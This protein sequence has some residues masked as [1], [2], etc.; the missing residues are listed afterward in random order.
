MDDKQS[1]DHD[2]TMSA[3]K[4][5]LDLGSVENNNIQSTHDK[6]F[7]KRLLRKIDWRLLPILGCLYTLALVDRS[8][9]AVARIAGMDEDLGLDQGNRASIILFV[10]FVPYILFEL[11]SNAFI[12]K[13]GAANWLAF[14]AVAFGLVTLGVGFLNSWE[15]LAV[16]RTLLGLFEAGFFPGT[17]TLS[18]CTTPCSSC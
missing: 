2:E 7:E 17:S 10:F 14:L 9:V 4:E 18:K 5:D 13:L 3:S 6:A 12:H 11:P 8:N 15:G 16:L 1:V